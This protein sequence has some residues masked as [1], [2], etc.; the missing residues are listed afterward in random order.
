MTEQQLDA[1]ISKSRELAI[2]VSQRET[3]VRMQK[4]RLS[5]GEAEYEKEKEELEAAVL[6]LTKRKQELQRTIR[7]RTKDLSMVSTRVS[8]LEDAGKS[9]QL[10]RARGFVPEFTKN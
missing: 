9:H 5:V 8:D 7:T 4:Q 2:Q 1:A 6:A 3:A 10:N